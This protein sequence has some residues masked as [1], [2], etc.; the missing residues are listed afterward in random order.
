MHVT[1]EESEKYRR[2]VS[3]IAMEIGVFDFKPDDILWH[4]KWVW[5]SGDIAKRDDLRDSGVVPK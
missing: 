1:L 2:F 5:F 4:Y 3:D